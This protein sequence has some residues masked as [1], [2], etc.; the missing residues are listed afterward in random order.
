MG[1]LL[2]G[3]SNK[4]AEKSQQLQQSEAEAQQRRTLAQLAA[5]Q[6][7]TDQAAAGKTGR[8][9]GSRLLTFLTDSSFSAAGGDKFGQ[10]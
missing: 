10:V 8:K 5:Q 2:G 3:G 6:A 4:A 9:T 7:E 1:N